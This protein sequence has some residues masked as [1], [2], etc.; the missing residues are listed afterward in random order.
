M[1][2][3][4]S[5]TFLVDVV[6]KLLMSNQLLHEVVITAII[7]HGDKY[8]IT[9]RSPNKKRFPGMWTVPGGHLESQDYLALPKDTEFYWYNVLERTLAREVKEEV[10]IMVKNVNYLTSLATVHQDG[11]PS[12][13]ISCLAEYLSGEVKLDPSESDAYEW[14]TI[15]QAKKYELIDGIYEELLMV[16]KKKSG[17]EN[18]LWEKS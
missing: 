10:G 4:N 13:V 6:M 17:E 7:I 2:I 1:S 12:I 8:L 16:E 15:E 5:C 9:R 14:V 3:I 11:S 18:V